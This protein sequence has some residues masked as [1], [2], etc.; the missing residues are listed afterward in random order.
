MTITVFQVGV[1][2]ENSQALDSATDFDVGLLACPANGESVAGR[3]W[4]AFSVWDPTAPRANF[5]YLHEL[6]LVMDAK[7]ASLC[8]PALEQSGELIRLSVTGIDEFY[9]YNPW[10]TFPH[11]AVDWAA[12]KNDLGMYSNLS[13]RKEFIPSAS[14]FRLPKMHELYLSSELAGSEADFF[15]LYQK[16]GLSGLYFK[17]LWDESSG[18]VQNRT[19]ARGFD[20]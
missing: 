11:D 7:A 17:K 13:L 20:R 12:T 5:F 10:I 18:P 14:I 6:F 8:K 15:Y 1:D 3:P 19:T 9:L 4:P 2:V 16:H